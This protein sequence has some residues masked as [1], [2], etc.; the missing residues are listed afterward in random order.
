M[1][2]GTRSRSIRISVAGALVG[3]ALAWSNAAVST[4]SAT[5]YGI[6]DLGALGGSSAAGYGVTEFG[7]VMVGQ[8]Q[9][10]TGAYHAFAQ[11][12][13]G[14]R[15]LGTLGG[16]QSTAFAVAGDQVVGQAQTAS[17]QQH[18]FFHSLYAGGP[19]TDLGT[20]GGTWSAA[21]GL[22][23]GTIVGAS[24]TAENRRMRAFV[25]TTGTTMSP[26]TLDWGGDS[27]AK[28]V[29]DNLIVGY[30]CTSGNASCRAFAYRDGVATN[31][32]SFGGNSVANAVNFNQQIV[33]TSGFAGSARTHAFLFANGTMRDLGTLGGVNSEGLDIN[34]RGDV[35]GTSDTA[36]AGQH[37]FL[38]RNGVM[39]DLNTLLP[40]G[41]GWIL[42]SAAS[43]S[44]GGQIVGTG[45]L[46]GVTRG[47]LM[48][49]PVDLALRSVGVYSQTDSNLPRGI[50]VGKT[51]TFVISVQ[52]LT[53][54]GVTVHGARLTDTLTGPAEFVGASS[55]DNRVKCQVAPTTVTCDW[56]PFDS[57]GLGNEVRLTARA[58]APGTI[59][60]RA[61]VS[62]DTPDPN[63]A[64]DS[65]SE[66]N[67]AVALA[68]LTLTPSTLAGGKASSSRVT[69]TDIAPGSDAVV[70]LSSSRPDIAPVPA[71]IVVVTGTRSRTFNII[72]KVVSQSTPVEISATYGM[73]TIKQTLTVVPPVLTYLYLSPTT[74]IGGCRTSAGK[75]V[76]SGAAPAGG[77]VVTLSNANSMAIVPASVTVPAGASSATFTVGTRTVITPYIG[78]VTAS[79]GGVS[80]PVTVTVRPIRVKTLVLSPNPA[81]GGT[82]VTASFTLECA[83]PPGGI[84]LSLTSGNRAVAA[85]T[86]SS[87]TVPAG[88]TSGSFSVQTSRVTASTAVWIHA[89]AYRVRKSAS[90]TVLP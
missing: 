88:A 40:A 74:I 44:D 9:T 10:A 65:V 28:A 73:V 49:P 87:V 75:V 22:E 2:S 54:D 24:R 47:F 25:Y 61:V 11:G 43:I 81:T 20:L 80:K 85:P 66:T 76:L 21:Y 63:S 79:Y 31:L 23:Y 35:V 12:W 50:Q 26:L 16:A 64:N 5:H 33:G 17:G 77:A 19:L 29:A 69:L 60:H 18:A 58:T 62:N 82:T 45:T 14:L 56:G 68:S 67:W 34:S 1:R 42:R 83:A 32:G 46:N 4:Q 6:A 52:A 38:W 53:E 70:R 3:I 55:F 59:S 7:Q 89:W 15:D 27:A 57:P 8:A 30:A 48:S 39:T 13:F 72:P 84:V 41:S 78:S 90:L 71:T 86:V 37:A 36:D 51:V